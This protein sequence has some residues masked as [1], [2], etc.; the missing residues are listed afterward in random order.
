MRWQIVLLPLMTSAGLSQQ[1]TYKVDAGT[2]ILL[3]PV[4][5]ISTKTAA[6][7]D[8][9]YLRTLFPVASGGRIVI[10]QGSWVT[11]TITEVKRA[12]HGQRSGELQV[13]FDSLL[14]ANGV[15]RKFHGDLGALDASNG[16]NVKRE[17]SRLT[18]PGR[19]KKA[20]IGTI[21]GTAAGGMAVGRLAELNSGNLGGHG[22]LIGLGIGAAAGTIAILAS[23]GPEATISQGSAVVIVLDEPLIFSA[24]ELDLTKCGAQNN[25]NY[26]RIAKCPM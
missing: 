24:S 16:G 1:G 3:S 26:T 19:N 8:R 22:D 9:I 2:R 21:G 13:H 7:G 20:A 23:R 4:N 25:E 5:S 11:G 12:R 14:L 18:G 6:A 17:E 15:D 10:P